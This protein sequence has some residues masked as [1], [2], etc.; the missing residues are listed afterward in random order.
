MPIT[1][2][3]AASANNVID[4]KFLVPPPSSSEVDS[5]F[6]R[7]DNSVSINLMSLNLFDA[8]HNSQHLGS[9]STESD[10]IGEF[11]GN[12][13]CG[14]GPAHDPMQA[15]EEHSGH[16]MQ[17]VLV[18]LCFSAMLLEG[19]TTLC[20]ASLCVTF[21]SSQQDVIPSKR[22]AST[23]GAGLHMELHRA[24]IHGREEYTIPY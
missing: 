6:N 11:F 17:V 15:S 13:S 12:A 1:P 7:S 8:Q 21:L 24:L 2:P 20:V 4:M 18:M 23:F 5:A 16:Q 19:K 3:P 9:N 22:Q 14:A 10:L